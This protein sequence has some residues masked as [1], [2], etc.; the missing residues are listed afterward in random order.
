MPE[1]VQRR[2]LLLTSIVL[3]VCS[4]QLMAASVHDPS[5]ARLGARGIAAI[6]FPFE[7]L[8]HEVTAS[9]KYVWTRYLWLVDV[10]KQRDQLRERV[11][12]LEALNS[13]FIE[14]KNENSRLSD[15]LRFSQTTGNRGIVATVVGRDPSNWVSTIT[16][17]RGSADGIR[18]G[19]AVVDGNAIVGQTTVVNTRSAKVLLLTDN[20]S[21]IDA[22]VQSSRVAGIIEGSGDGGLKMRYAERSPDKIVRAGERVIASG[23]DGVYPKGTL[24]GVVQEA[25]EHGSAL[26]QN[27]SV[28]PSVAVQR[29]ENVQVLLP[30]YYR[31]RD[32][33]TMFDASDTDA[34]S[35][36]NLQCGVTAGGE[37]S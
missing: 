11:R 30:E 27:I 24:I 16:I 35:S 23:L 29:L 9:A 10:E 34:F 20:A 15:L 5:L 6:L 33:M 32:P 21:A 22:I 4:M 37:Q 19:L 1:F 2:G 25:A 13:K 7:R 12:E 36:T 8:H 17:D 18:P 26:F 14:F 3:F 28:K 31:P